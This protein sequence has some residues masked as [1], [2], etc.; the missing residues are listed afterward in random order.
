MTSNQVPR[1]KIVRKDVI[2]LLRAVSLLHMLELKIP[3]KFKERKEE[4]NASERTDVCE[5]A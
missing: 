2:L 5:R 3:R 4:R 1:G